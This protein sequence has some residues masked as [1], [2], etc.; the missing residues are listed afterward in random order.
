[1]KIK[2]NN[3]WYDGKE[4]PIMILFDTIEEKEM[5]GN[6]RPQDM[7]YSEFPDGIPKEDLM[8]FMEVGEKYVNGY[9]PKQKE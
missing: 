3:V 8:K 2:V 9:V 4:T 5:I 6:M 7:K 1:M